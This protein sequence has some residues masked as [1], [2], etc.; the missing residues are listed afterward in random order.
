MN[1]YFDKQQRTRAATA[2]AHE[3]GTMDNAHGS[4]GYGSSTAHSSPIKK[5]VTQGRATIA[6]T[7]TDMSGA[8]Q[9]DI[10]ET[11]HHINGNPPFEHQTQIP[12]PTTPTTNGDVHHQNVQTGP[13]ITSTISHETRTLPLMGDQLPVGNGVP[14]MPAHAVDG[15]QPNGI[16]Y[17]AMAP[18][19]TPI[20]DIHGNLIAANAMQIMPMPSSVDYRLHPAHTFVNGGAYAQQGQMQGHADGNHGYTYN[21]PHPP[22]PHPAGYLSQEQVR[23]NSMSY[24]NQLY[25]KR[26]NHEEWKHSIGNGTPV[27]SVN[28]ESSPASN[29]QNTPPAL[30]HGYKYGL[31]GSASDGSMAQYNNRQPAASTALV[32]L[33]HEPI[34]NQPTVGP[35]DFE[36]P[37]KETMANRS[38][39]L[40]ALTE[41]GRPSG[42]DLFDPKFLPFIAGYKYSNPPEE[43]GVIVIRNV[44]YYIMN[45][46]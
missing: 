44:S 41:N 2:S 7:E 11:E 45:T 18:A 15:Q 30:V 16:H 37:S 32:Q 35:M 46:A 39:M 27:M 13:Q 1:L 33:D 40:Q 21:Q 26:I 20:F 17:N 19:F 31:P 8:E 14:I 36:I 42:D 28:G 9:Q 24:G 43:N 22:P 6:E 25:Q 38:E 29:T 10:G 12:R 5:M 4:Y 23:E 34:Q 3:Q